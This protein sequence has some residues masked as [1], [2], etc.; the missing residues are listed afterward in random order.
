MTA[1]EAR[2]QAQ[3]GEKLLASG[4]V[5]QEQHETLQA[6]LQRAEADVAAARAAVSARPSR[7]GSAGPW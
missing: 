4:V 2:Q 1:A 7:E 3:R 6:A 5:T